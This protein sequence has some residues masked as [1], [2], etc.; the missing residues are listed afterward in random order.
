MPWLLLRNA[1]IAAGMNLD[2]LFG[3]VVIAG[4]CTARNAM[5]MEIAQNATATQ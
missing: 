2:S 3:I 1:P 4:A 5:K